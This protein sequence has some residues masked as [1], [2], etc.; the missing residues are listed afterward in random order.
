MKTH[1]KSHNGKNFSRIIILT[2]IFLLLAVIS[3]YFLL[4]FYYRSGF[5]L[6]T[7]ING[8]YCTG[9]TVEEVNEELLS[10]TEAPVV[11]LKTERYGFI[12]RI[13]LEE[14]GFSCEYMPV[15]EAYM[16][17]SNPLLWVDNITFH[18]NHQIL[19]QI[20]YDEKEFRKAF[21]STWSVRAYSQSLEC[22]ALQYSELKNG[23]TL[24]D[25]LKDRIDIDKAFKLVMEAVSQGQGE[26]IINLDELDCFYDVPMNEEQKQI[27]EMWNKLDAFQNFDLVY[28]MGDEQI[29]LS[30]Y[31]EIVGS[32]IKN[33]YRADIGDGM[34]YP[35]TD[36][37]GRFVLNEEAVS[38][39]VEGLADTYDTYGKDREFMSTRGDIVTVPAGGTYG[40]K[41]DQK[42]ELKYLMENLLKEDFHTGTPHLHVPEYEKQG[43]VRG[44]D[45]IGDTYIE[46]D[47]TEQKMYYYEKGELVIET[48][49]VTGN[50]GR[51][52]GTPQGVNYVYN[53]QKNR[54]LRGPGYA[55]PVKFWVP[56]KGSIGIHDASWRSEFG[57]EIY[58]TNGSHGC[59][60][61]P[62]DIMAELYDAVEIGT[63]V[64]IFY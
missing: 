31:P 57:G 16:E 28:D 10:R 13:S 1:M 27:E 59:I 4:A 11:V 12:D 3:G 17:E 53:K 23:W 39:F 25:G 60:N 46:V 14:F 61:T 56:V 35:V 6:N 55:S 45:D 42:T 54:V 21:E 8:V 49:V 15:L 34:Y 7:W 52:M 30:C 18:K 63:P 24:Y 58:K 43:V 20:T 29:S 26:I 40:T 22:Y 2:I 44:R 9:K 64:V 19:P 62:T 36:G 51:R 33:E 47:M 41:L 5:S 32:F 38:L 50:T 37:Q 48:D